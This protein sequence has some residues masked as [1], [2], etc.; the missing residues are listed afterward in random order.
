VG[1]PEGIE[2]TG[3]KGYRNLENV[4]GKIPGEE[5]KLHQQHVPERHLNG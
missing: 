5:R 2:G 4:F 3:K 1:I